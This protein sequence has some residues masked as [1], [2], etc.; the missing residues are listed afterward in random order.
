M[1]ESLYFR[2]YTMYAINPIITITNGIATM[3]II[4]A[5][6]VYRIQLLQLL[7]SFVV[8]VVTI[9]VVQELD[10]TSTG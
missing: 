6:V 10:G 4:A 5:I 2:K 8:M 9:V 1:A 3:P 7:D